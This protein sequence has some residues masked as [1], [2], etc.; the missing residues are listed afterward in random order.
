MGPAWGVLCVAC[1]SANLTMGVSAFSAASPTPN[2]LQLA[3]MF[4]SH[5]T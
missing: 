4:P 5:C 3:S 1:E 2:F